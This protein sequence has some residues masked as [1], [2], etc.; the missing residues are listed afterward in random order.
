MIFRQSSIASVLSYIGV[1]INYL[2][3]L[4]LLPRF[5]EPEQIGIYC[6]VKNT[7]LLLVPFAQLGFGQ[8]SVIRFFPLFKDQ[9]KGKESFLTFVLVATFIGFSLFAGL[10]F[11]SKDLLASIFIERAAKL[12]PYFALILLTTFFIVINVVLKAWSRSH[13]RI[14]PPNF[15]Q[16]VLLGICSV[17]MVGLYALNYLSF[18]YLVRSI[19]LVYF[20][21]ILSQISYLA[22]LGEFSLA[23]HF[24]YFTKGFI[25]RFARYAFYTLVGSS[26]FVILT[27]IDDVMISSMIGLKAAGIYVTLSYMGAFIETPRR[28][29]RQITSPVIADLLTKENFKE[30]GVLYRRLSIHQFLIAF[31]LLL[32]VLVNLGNAL[33]VIPHHERYE[34]GKFVVIFIGLSKLLDTPFGICSELILMSKYYRYNI[35]ALLLLV[36][37]SIVTNYLLIP[38]FGINGA[39]IAT[40]IAS[41]VYNLF[42]FLFVFYKFKLHPFRRELFY[43]PVAGLL[44]FFSTKLIPSMDGVVVDVLV[45]SLVLLLVYITATFYLKISPE[46]N[47]AI[48][49]K[50]LR[51][52]GR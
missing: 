42:L 19:A 51:L 44:A 33:Y 30:I 21:G 6:L 38:F 39:A 17:G 3:V 48:L 4:W 15:V 36:A 46:L 10:C 16:H 50:W 35:V 31:C 18:P 13:F 9:P 20:I 11:L 2:I 49:R 47:A 1:G 12:I 24:E 25:I 45:R 52:K 29:L 27:K 7:S 41:L 40:M 43:V 34:V 37:A 23:F 8:S 5:L 22:F 32:L 26:G 28:M 14:I